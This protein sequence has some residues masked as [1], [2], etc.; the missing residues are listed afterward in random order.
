MFGVK[1]KT[2]PKIMSEELVKK[3]CNYQKT[4]KRKGEGRNSDFQL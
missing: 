1:I 3:Y 2:G 4:K